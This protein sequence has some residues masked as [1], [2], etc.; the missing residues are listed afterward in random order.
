MQRIIVLVTIM[1]LSIMAR[2]FTPPRRFVRHAHRLLSTMQLEIP[3]VEDM[4]DLGALLCNLIPR[5]RPA[6]ICLDGDLGAG[7]TTL[8][9]GFVRQFVQDEDLRVTSPTYLLSYTYRDSDDNEYVLFCCDI[10]MLVS[11]RSGILLFALPQTP[12]YGLV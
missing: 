12:P 11:C 10:G 4:D 9:R 8:S 1:L 6:V 3:L 5:G 7:K 2:S